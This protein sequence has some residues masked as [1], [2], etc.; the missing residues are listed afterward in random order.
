VK[1][2][3]FCVLD[4]VYYPLRAREGVIFLSLNLRHTPPQLNFTWYFLLRSAPP[5]SDTPYFE[6]CGKLT[7][8]R[9]DELSA[10]INVFRKKM[11]E[12]AAATQVVLPNK[13]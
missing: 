10:K 12:T 13:K 4:F 11:E 9:L 7:L 1:I 3:R 2:C 5:V 8:K 6:E